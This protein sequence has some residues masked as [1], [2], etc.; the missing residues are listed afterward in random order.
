[1]S[2]TR[3]KLKLNCFPPAFMNNNFHTLP[4]S[5]PAKRGHFKAVTAMSL[6]SL[7][8]CW[9]RPRLTLGRQFSRR[10]NVI[11]GCHLRGLRWGYKRKSQPRNCCSWKGTFGGTLSAVIRPPPPGCMCSKM[12][13]SMSL[14][15]FKYGR[16]IQRSKEVWARTLWPAISELLFN[17]VMLSRHFKA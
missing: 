1:M 4:K 2:S 3:L 17:S 16:G 11:N 6:S 13:S 8:K 10:P 7:A 9:G 5:W 14:S 12:K 15:K